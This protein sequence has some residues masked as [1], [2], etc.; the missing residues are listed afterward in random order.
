[1]GLS[2]KVPGMRW[3]FDCLLLLFSGLSRPH[4]L[5]PQS[6]H[7]ISF[8][9]CVFV[10]LVLYISVIGTS[11]SL[12]LFLALFLSLQAM[13]EHMSV[14]DCDP[15]VL[16]GLAL[17]RMYRLLGS[18]LADGRMNF[19]GNELAHP[20]GLDLPRPANHF[21]MAKAFRRWNLADS[22]SLKFT[23]CEV[24]QSRIIFL[25]PAMLLYP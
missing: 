25:Y 2:L 22:P 12:S 23:Q 15:H 24:R 8:R 7:A 14:E 9:W 13:Y 5:V 17:W 6:L 16:S 11:F 19:I 10:C 21:S 20:D 1:M 4:M 3:Q 18:G